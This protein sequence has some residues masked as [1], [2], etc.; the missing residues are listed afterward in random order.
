[1]P[2]LFEHVQRECSVMLAGPTTFAA[3]LHAFQVNHRSMA[4][5]KQSSEVWKVL[6]AVRSEF[7]KYNETV[8]RVAKQLKTASGSVEELDRRVKIM[9]RALRR[10][11]TLPD[12][13]SAAALLGLDLA[14][15]GIGDAPSSFVMSDDAAP[16]HALRAAE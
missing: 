16:A 11:E 4:I 7:R 15:A 13:A 12:D 6:G 8:A 1:M 2:G 5:A 14:E 10:V 9:D 3:I